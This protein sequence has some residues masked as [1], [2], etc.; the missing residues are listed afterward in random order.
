MGSGL[1]KAIRDRPLLPRRLRQITVLRR[2]NQENT[3][4]PILWETWAGR[5]HH[6]LPVFCNFSPD[7]T[8]HVKTG[9][10]LPL[11]QWCKIVK[12]PL[13]THSKLHSNYL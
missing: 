5:P 9:F 1:V 4:S 13:S 6:N 11:R 12:F 7:L 10:V 3:R 8:Y 2:A